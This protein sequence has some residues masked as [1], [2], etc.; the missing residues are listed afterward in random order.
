MPQV[1]GPPYCSGGVV[2]RSPHF[3]VFTTDA[4]KLEVKVCLEVN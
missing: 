4:M 3:V 2:G 1:A